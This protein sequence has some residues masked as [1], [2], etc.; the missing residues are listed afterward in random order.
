MQWGLVHKVCPAVE[1][2]DRIKVMARELAKA[3]PEAISAGLTYVQRTR[4]L[5]SEEAGKVAAELRAGVMAS[6]DFK[7]GVAAFRQKRE[8]RWPA[9]PPAFYEND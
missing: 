6:G 7:E 5:G 9:L 3:S 2:G 1:L 4:G 8:P